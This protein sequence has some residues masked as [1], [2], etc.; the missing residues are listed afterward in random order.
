MIIMWVV[1]EAI[2]VSWVVQKGMYNKI[3][4]YKTD[5]QHP[6]NCGETCLFYTV[7]IKTKDTFYMSLIGRNCHFMID[8]A[9]LAHS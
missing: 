9:S 5:I 4:K 7:D 3:G 1:K 6:L 2:F 8:C